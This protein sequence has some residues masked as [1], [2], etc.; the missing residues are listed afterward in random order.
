MGDNDAD[1]EFSDTDG[2]AKPS[3]N[4]SFHNHLGYKLSKEE[5]NKLL[6]EKWNYNWELEVSNCKW[7]GTGECFLKELDMNSCYGLKPMLYEH[8]LSIF[9]ESGSMIFIHLCR[10]HSSQSVSKAD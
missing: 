6:E 4:S 2:I 5:V 3:M 9:M 10:D 1:S 8:W 7:K